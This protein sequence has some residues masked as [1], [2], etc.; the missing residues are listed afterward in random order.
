MSTRVPKYHYGQPV[1]WGNGVY[2]LFFV[3]HVNP[4]HCPD[5]CFSYRLSKIHLDYTGYTS[6]NPDWFGEANQVSEEVLCSIDEM[7]KVKNA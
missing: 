5:A 7:P 2:Q 6:A 1:F 4:L 3:S